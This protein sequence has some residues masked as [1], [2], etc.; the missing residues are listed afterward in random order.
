ME[1]RASLVS[2]P[3]WYLETKKTAQYLSQGYDKESLRKR[4]I[5]DNLYETR[6]DYRAIEILTTITTRLN[7]LPKE[8]LLEIASGDVLQSKILVLISIMMN[9]KLFFEFMYDVF[10]DK[11]AI[12]EYIITN[13]DLEK[14][15]ENKALQSDAVKNW[16]AKTIQKLKQSYMKILYDANIISSSLPPRNI[17]VPI[18]HENIVDI[19]KKNNMDAYLRAIRGD[20]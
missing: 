12:G 11:I 10:Q 4:V 18:I 19:L 20:S 3:I 7:K 14:F 8:L 15:F 16:S 13:R 17:I 5:E 1:Y 9:D 2:K 6:A